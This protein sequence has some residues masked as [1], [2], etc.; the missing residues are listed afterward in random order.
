MKKIL[1]VLFLV[2]FSLTG[3]HAQRTG[4]YRQL[5]LDDNAGNIFT[6]TTLAGSLGVNNPVPNPSSVVD[7]AST[8]RGILL[9]RVAGTGVVSP[10][11]GLLLF[12]TNT[13]RFVYNFG[14]SVT[15]NWQELLT[16]NSGWMT[17]GNAGLVDGTNN[18]LGTLNATPIRFVTNGTLNERMRIDAAGNVGIGT[19]TPQ[20]VLD[21]VSTTGGFIVPRMTTVQRTALIAVKGMIVYDT[22]LDQFFRYGGA[23]PAWASF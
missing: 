16:A 10:A 2:V 13:N 9:P 22:T 14:T 18:F 3:A 12:N 15:P 19:P 23:V 7:I 4:G 11:T 21:V 17:T 1:S 5:Q 20:G 6:L 8:N